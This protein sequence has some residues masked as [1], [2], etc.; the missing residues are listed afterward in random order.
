MIDEDA[1][2]RSIA[3]FKQRKC[4]KKE[5]GPRC[6]FCPKSRHPKSK[7]ACLAC[8]AKKREISRQHQGYK[9]GVRRGR[10]QIK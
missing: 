3:E 2:L 8:L 10:P 7:V 1:M 5:R 4:V 6:R 9:G